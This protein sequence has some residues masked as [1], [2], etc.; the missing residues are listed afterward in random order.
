MSYL[1]LSKSFDKKQFFQ[2]P[3]WDE[4]AG[5][6]N[7]D[8]YRFNIDVS[9]EDIK[10]SME[11]IPI[12]Y[13][14]A[15]YCCYAVFRKNK[16]NGCKNLITGTGSEIPE[17]NCYFQEINRGSLLQPNDITANVI[18]HNHVVSLKLTKNDSFF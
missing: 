5:Q 4:M 1:Q 8:L 15:G 18:L 9:D 14:L 12:I 16:C 3:N 2:E 10:E 13:Y 17:I 6:Q 7:L 11:V